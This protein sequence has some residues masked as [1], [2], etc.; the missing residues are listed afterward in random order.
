MDAVQPIQPF[1]SWI[2]LGFVGVV[3]VLIV[4]SVNRF[5]D[6]MQT[7]RKEVDKHLDDHGTRIVVLETKSNG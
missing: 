5:L 4:A 1:L 7:W 3:G 6:E 2:V